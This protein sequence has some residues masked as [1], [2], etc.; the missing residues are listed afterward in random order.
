MIRPFPLFLLVVTLPSFPLLLQALL[1]RIVYTKLQSFSQTFIYRI[2]LVARYSHATYPIHSS[3]EETQSS[4][5]AMKLLLLLSTLLISTFASPLSLHTRQ[6]RQCNLNSAFCDR[7]YSNVS[8]IGTHNSAFTGSLDDPR[9]NQQKSVTEQLDTG[10]RFLQAQV[11]EMLGMLRMCHTECVLFDAGSLEDY[12]DTV[13]KWMDAHPD[14]VVTVLLVNGDN[15]K[16]EMFDKAFSKTGLKDLAFVPPT[17]PDPLP[18]DNWP[19]LAEFIDSKKRLVTFLSS[20]AN[21]AS[22]PYLLSE[23]DHYVFETPFETT[24]PT[25][26]SCELD[27]PSGAAPDGRMYIMNH[28]LQVEILPNILIPA[29]DQNFE[30]NAATGRG[31]IGAQVVVC[32]GKWGRKPNFVLVDMFHRGKVFEAQAAMNGV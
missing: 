5:G 1:T 26:P 11:H 32:E 28:F 12:L 22:I 9:V 7:K 24:D 13:K 10:I 20:Q 14:E 3:D 27:R 15:V 25:F 4:T 30:T 16:A 2:A 8:F 23:F 29:N 18:L 19:T 17:S 6:D 21:E 31:S